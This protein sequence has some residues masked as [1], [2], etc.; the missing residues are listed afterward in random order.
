MHQECDY[1]GRLK[2]KDG[3]ASFP[4]CNTRLID[5]NID[6]ECPASASQGPPCQNGGSCWEGKCCCP[7]GFSGSKC[8]IKLDLC[9]VSSCYNGGTCQASLNGFTC[10]CLDGFTGA[11]CQNQVD[12]CLSKPCQN[13]GTC[14][15]L[16]QTYYCSCSI[17]KFFVKAFGI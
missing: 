7:A 1:F 11:Y 15:T 2:C 14:V 17:G 6:P 5:P 4:L 8:E 3:W 13:N 9:T 10:K 12:H 16:Y